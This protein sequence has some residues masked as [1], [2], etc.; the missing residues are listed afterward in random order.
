MHWQWLGTEAKFGR[1]AIE[2]PSGA[3][4]DLQ[5]ESAGPEIV[6]LWGL[7]GPLRPKNRLEKLGGFTPHLFQWVLRYGFEEEKLPRTG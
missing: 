2:N 3:D 5:L 6:K 4:R 1:A 7:N